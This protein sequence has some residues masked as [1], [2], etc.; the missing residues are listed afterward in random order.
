MSVPVPGAR[1]W[2]RE[3]GAGPPLVLV[4]GGTGTGEHDW[5]PVLPALR[6]RFRTVLIDLRGHGS[7]PDPELDLRMTRFGLDLTHLLRNL[8]IP[9]AVFLGFSVGA[10]TLLTLLARQPQLAIALITVGASARGEEA[11]VR[12]ITSGPWPDDLTGLRHAVGDGP[13]YWRRLRSALAEDWAQNLAFSDTELARID[14]PTLICHGSSDRIVR[15]DESLHLFGALP[16]A[17]LFVLPDAGHQAQLDN[18]ATFL[19]GITG[20][21]DRVLAAGRPALAAGA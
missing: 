15:L 17:Q 21:L 20:F 6:E 8:G 4:H 11:R 9:R 10:N 3:D 1:I 5:A 18:T 7:S 13:E 2:F 16:D 19:A 14:C 12:K